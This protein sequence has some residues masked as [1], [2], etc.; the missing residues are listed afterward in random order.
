MTQQKIGV[1]LVNLGT[2]AQPTSSAIR[3]FLKPFLSDPRVIDYPK[4]LWKPLLH[5]FV[6]PFRPRKVKTLYQHVWTD[7][8]SPLLVNTARQEAALQA[9][10]DKGEHAILVRAAMAYSQPSLSDRI[11]EFLKEKV[12]KMIVLPLFPQYSST[13]TAA[14]FDAFAQ[15]LK[16]AKAIPPF[17]FIHHYYE[18]PSYIQALAKTITLQKDE[19]LLFSFHGIP[20]RYAAEGNYY[21]EH[22]QQTAQLIAAA[23]G[24][25]DNQW[26]LVYQSRFGPEEWTKPYA[27]ETLAQLPKEGK[28]NVAVICPG[29]AVD[30]LETLEE[31]DKTNQALFMAAGGQSYR[32]IPALNDSFSHIQLLAELISEKI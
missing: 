21:T 32:Y 10:F 9:Y 16:K 6:L 1:L 22:C 5:T 28:K 26:S 2:P 27:D 7:K 13:T 15:S 4:Y 30:C 18:R 23:A 11:D 29:F 8:G 12:S 20:K 3:K 17:E 25:S 31:M 19:Y 24:L 14:V